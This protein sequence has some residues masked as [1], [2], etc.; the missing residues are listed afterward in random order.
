M[1]Y[2]FFVTLFFIS[3]FEIHAIP[4]YYGEEISVIGKLEKKM[5]QN[6]TENT[7]EEV[8]IL[9]LDNPIDT[10]PM[11]QIGSEKRKEDN[12]K[13]LI[14]YFT[15]DLG[16]QINI[17]APSKS[18][19][20]KGSIWYSDWWIKTFPFL[21]IVK[22][23]D[24]IHKLDEQLANSLP[25]CVKSISQFGLYLEYC[26]KAAK[27][28]K[29]FSHFKRNPMYRCILEHATYDQGNQYLDYIYWIYPALMKKMEE[30]KKNDALGNPVTYN[31]PI[32]GTISPTTLQYLKVAGD[33]HQYFGDLSKFKIVEI[34]GGYGGQCV[35]LSKI[36]GFKQYTIIDLPECLPLL[37][38]YLTASNIYNVNLFNNKQL[39]EIPAAD[40]LISNYAFSEISYEDQLD[41]L[42]KLI[43]KVPNG[44]MII[45]FISKLFGIHSITE[46]ELV[47]AL[48]LTG[49]NV[50][51][52]PENP[53]TGDQN[54]VLIWKSK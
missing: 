12:I 21:F 32:V 2:F 23:I 6:S 25:I 43:K 48:E 33:L 51:V 20:I 36:T 41:Y 28:D 17:L 46:K 18:I 37:K 15:C 40:L 16:E 22:E 9:H 42:E 11:P 35:I 50:K 30:V 44:Y 53:Q 8:W 31:Y 4:H 54:V 29:E 13:E 49:A 10:L 24:V 3:L 5:V 27:D 38:R 39:D 45:N 34:G 7:D 1:K 47:Q 26:S 19:K 14:L 52:F